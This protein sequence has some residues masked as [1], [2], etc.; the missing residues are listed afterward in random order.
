MIDENYER[1]CEELEGGLEGLEALINKMVSDRKRK[2]YTSLA[3]RTMFSRAF[4]VLEYMSFSRKKSTEGRR[5][6]RAYFKDFFDM[7]TDME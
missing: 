3:V 6:L 7:W 1:L 2:W 5:V 4:N